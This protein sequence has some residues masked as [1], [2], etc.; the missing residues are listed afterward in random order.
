M[1]NLIITIFLTTLFAYLHEKK[2]TKNFFFIATIVTLSLFIGLRTGYNDTWNYIRSFNN[3]EPLSEFLMDAERMHL[4]HNP[5]FYGIEAW[6][7]GI[8][9]NYHIYFMLFA[10]LDSV[11]I[12]RFLKKYSYG[13]FSYAVFLFWGYGLGTFGLAAMK[14]FTAMAIL[15]LAME[16]MLEKKW[17][18]FIIIV[19]IAGLI[20]T[21]AFMFLVLPFFI[22]EPWNAKI[23]GICGL[24]AVIMYTFNSTIAAVLEY[25]DSVGKYVADFEVFDGIQMNIWRVLV[26]AVVPMAIYVFRSRLIPQMNRMQALLSNMSIIS[27]MFMLLGTVNGANMFGRLATYY[28]FGS[29]CMLGW[30]I[31]QVFNE[32]SKKFLITLSY[33]LFIGFILYDNIDFATTGAYSSITLVEFLKSILGV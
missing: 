8:T 19:I 14:Q 11:L 17:M 27:L 13:F 29:I 6:L 28:V 22:T 26:F 1:R 33:V 20:H 25:A 23:M 7:H 21:Y 32:Q 30:I 9:D 31:E 3:V 15:T 2:Y 24:T 10:A 18:R 4:L 5:L 16:A 12:I